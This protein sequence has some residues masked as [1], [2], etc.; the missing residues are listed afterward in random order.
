M[1]NTSSKFNRQRNDSVR[2]HDDSSSTCRRHQV[3]QPVAVKVRTND[4][5]KRLPELGKLLLAFLILFVAAMS[6]GLVMS[7]THQYAVNYLNKTEPLDDGLFRLIPLIQW[8]WF[9]ADVC[10]GATISLS[11]L[12]LVFHRRQITVY[13]RA[14]LIAAFLY[15]LRGVT[16]ISTYLPPPFPSDSLRCLP[17]IDISREPFEYLNRAFILVAKMGSSSDGNL[18]LCGDTIFSGHTMIVVLSCWFLQHYSPQPMR[19][20]A[21]LVVFPLALLAIAFLIISRQHYTVDVVVAIFL[22]LPVLQV[23]HFWLREKRRQ[24][25][26]GPSCILHPLHN[27]FVFFEPNKDDGAFGNELSWPL[28]WPEFLVAYFQGLNRIRLSSEQVV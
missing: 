17:A 12:L 10:T 7:Y 4:E 24:Y 3:E 14:A 22:S 16:L 28:P 23:Y 27:L 1:S 25:V 5:T 15:C 8:T 9:A 13:K 11:F 26:K 18:I 20:M 21:L 2:R 6:N 19:L